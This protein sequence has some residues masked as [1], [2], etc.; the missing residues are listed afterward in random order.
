MR[1]FLVLPIVL[2]ATCHA[3]AETLIVPTDHPAIQQAIDA[4]VDGDR[5]VVLPGTYFENLDFRGKEISVIGRDGRSATTIDGQDLGPVVQFVS[6]EGRQSVLEGFTLYNGLSDAGGGIR[7]IGS[8]PTIRH[9]RIER[10]HSGRG[11][12]G[13]IYCDEGGPAIEHNVIVDNGAWRGGGIFLSRTSS[14][15]LGN[16]IRRNHS[17]SGGG[18][19][20]VEENDRSIF[21]ENEVSRNYGA[22]TGTRGGAMFISESSLYF[23]R[24]TFEGNI[25]RGLAAGLY[26]NGDTTEVVMRACRFVD[27]VGETEW[28]VGG[29][30]VKYGGSLTLVNCIFARNRGILTGALLIDGSEEQD[31]VAFCTFFGN[32]TRYSGAS[33]LYVLDQGDVAIANSILWNHVGTEDPEAHAEEGGRLTMASCLVRGGFEGTDILDADP[34]FVDVS[35]LDLHLRAD[36]PAIGMARSEVASRVLEDFEGHSRERDTPDMGADEALIEYTC[37]FGHSAEVGT[38]VL[39][40][41]DTW[42]DGERVVEV[43]IGD[44]LEVTVDTPEPDGAPA[45]FAIY[46]W[47]EEPDVTSVKVQQRDVGT[48][49]FPLPFNPGGDELPLA[50]FNNLGH[51]ER[52]GE[53]T[54]ESS[55]APTVLFDE[56]VSPL[57]PFRFTVQGIIYDSSA[58]SHVRTT[59]ALVFHR[60]D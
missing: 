55:A 51:E 21:I 58:E 37:R 7:C 27:N 18:G 41:N 12:G 19:I 22:L 42:G 48:T 15:V 50:I 52:L 33:T 11:R 59:N 57:A 45:L 39:R 2:W 29:A 20:R 53:A 24:N 47:P 14:D 23:Y 49:C 60:I 32:K 36:S 38:P 31:L 26:I 3:S 28:G 30:I 25:C 35:R 54:R 13:G 6:G 4:A 16:D 43:R 46:V 1:A 9:N 34:R 56:V 10:C 8:S 40:T 17:T 5:V 44:R